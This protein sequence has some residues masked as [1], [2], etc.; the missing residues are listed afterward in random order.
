MAVLEDL[1]RAD[2][3]VLALAQLELAPREDHELLQ[4]ELPGQSPA[5][6]GWKSAGLVPWTTAATSARPA[7]INVF[8]TSLTPP[9]CGGK[10]RRPFSIHSAREDVSLK[11]RVADLSLWPGSEPPR[12]KSLIADALKERA[13]GYLRAIQ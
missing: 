10:N 5:A 11:K 12:Q 8:D 6:T 3:H 2:N 4:E 13:I 7:S 9:R 1:I